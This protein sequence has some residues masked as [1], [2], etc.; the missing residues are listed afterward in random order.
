MR[1]LPTKYL[2]KAWLPGFG[3]R[4]GALALVAVALA[5]C[6]KA[7]T[8]DLQRSAQRQR[9][10]WQVAEIRTVTTDSLGRVISTVV[11]PDQGSIEFRSPTDPS[12]F[13]PVLFAGPCA[14]SALV[15]YFRR[16]GAG[17]GTTSGGWSLYWDADPEDRRLL[18]WGIQ[19]GGSLHRAVNLERDGADRLR[20]HY[21]LTSKLRATQREFISFE[22]RR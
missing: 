11:S 13:S 1:F 20:L 3:R 7:E 18:F 16:S 4:T 9:G 10:T 17:N 8:T 6:Q 14:G 21:I 12:P 15:D 22:L 2:M 5:G 19:A